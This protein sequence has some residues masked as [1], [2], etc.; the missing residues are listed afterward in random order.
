MTEK[1]KPFLKELV[2]FYYNEL[3]NVAGGSFHISLDDGNLSD[4]DIWLCQQEAKKNNDSFGVFLG[5]ILREFTEEERE[6]M[7]EEDW[8]GMR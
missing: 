6:K 5:L 3:G 8:W 7:Y 2:D 1:F 4:D